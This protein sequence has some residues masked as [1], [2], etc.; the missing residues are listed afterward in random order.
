[1]AVAAR[2]SM[3]AVGGVCS[4]GIFRVVDVPPLPA[5]ALADRMCRLADGMAVSAACAFTMLG[6]A[7]AVWARVGDDADGGFVRDSLAAAGLDVS[8]LR[9]IP[10]GRTSQAAVVVDATGRRLVVPFHDPGLD[11]A[12]DWLPLD[13]LRHAGIVHCDVRWP[14]AAE[15]SLRAARDRGVP[16]MIDGD[17]APAA[18]LHRL[19]PLADYKVFSDAGL[20]VFT[21]LSDVPAGLRAVAATHD[22]HVGATCGA[23]GYVWLE[24]GEIRRV[25]SPTVPAIDTLAAGDVF[26]GAFALAI[27]EGRS[28]AE[29]ARFACTAAALK[30]ARF[31]GRLG[32]PTRAEVDAAAA[33][34]T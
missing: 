33:A 24:E 3:I 5:K 13:R 22:G 27:L 29:S 11:A 15:A 32:C 9:T 2:P 1:M 18:V 25:P 17:V 7:A 26:H 12:T 10:G 6:G 31:G 4:T 20:E 14:E 34:S 28:V 21:G 30:C 8:G 23:D 16:T 19:V